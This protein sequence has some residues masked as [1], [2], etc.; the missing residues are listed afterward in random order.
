MCLTCDENPPP[1]TGR[2]DIPQKA[3]NDPAISHEHITIKNGDV[4]VDGFLARPV[5]TTPTQAVIVTHG[6]AGLPEDMCNAAAQMA[7]ADYLGLLLDPTSRYPDISQLSRDFL[8]SYGYIKLLLSD[9]EAAVDYLQ[10]TV[11]QISLLGFCGGGVLNLM[12]AA[13]HPGIRSVVAFYAPPR[14]HQN[15]TTNPRPDM[16]DFVAKLTIPIQCH[17]GTADPYIPLADIADF[18]SAV[19]DHKIDAEIYRYEGAQHGFYHYTDSEC[20]EPAD[21]ALACQRMIEFLASAPT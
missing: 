1:K 7:Q 8:M 20:Y 14:V 15:S 11:S 19:R 9:I 13:M 4:L 17:F 18:E 10:P 21:A 5:A 6:N 2:G 3:L 12:Y 16:L